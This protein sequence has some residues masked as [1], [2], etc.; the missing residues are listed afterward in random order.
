MKTPPIEYDVVIVGSGPTG[1]AYAR[2]LHEEAPRLR[3]L[4]VEAGPSLS[5]QPGLH[6]KNLQDPQERAA[7]QLASQGPVTSLSPES[8]V[9]GPGRP[10]TFL[11]RP[12][13]FAPL[14]GMPAAA[15]SSNVGGMGAHWTCACPRPGASERIFFLDDGTLDAALT[16]AER[17]L[18]VTAGAFIDAPFSAEVRRLL[19]HAF[20]RTGAT[21]IQPM[22][23]AVQKYPDGT[24]T[25]SGTDV[26]LGP[27]AEP[28]TRSDSFELL[29]QT[30]CQRVTLDAGRVTGVELKDL[31]TG[32]VTQVR[33]PAVVV[34]ADALRTPQLLFAS[35]VRPRAL[36]RYLNDQPQVISAVRLP[37]D[38][39]AEGAHAAGTGAALHSGV[40]W[41][42]YTDDEP[43]HGQVMQL[44][45]SPVPLADDDPVVP[46][47]VV[48]LGWFCATETVEENRVEF[49]DTS[50]DHYGMPRM[51]INYNL[52]W[53]DLRVIDEAKD[54]VTRAGKA[55]GTF[56]DDRPPFLLPA[57]SSLHYQ[58][59]VR[60]GQHDDG[61]SVCGPDSQV[62]GT[63]GLYVAG[64]GVIPTSTAC[65][66][67]LTSV[68]LA[69][70]GARSLARSLARSSQ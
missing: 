51:S 17:L 19:E 54:A 18:S 7:A 47:S 6:V 15:M 20:D 46:G 29:D 23:L 11:L 45:A 41:V 60:M 21:A 35:G 37:A 22:P 16:E 64:N 58:G 66:P 38:V 57:G 34:A 27:L 13:E 28:A 32:A 69:V 30:L 1:S 9:P 65:N 40:S 61:R 42:P 10:G 2:I 25:W 12:D 49:D 33:A 14:A 43:F 55:L 39:V 50:L 26:V 68:A 56:L 8:P 63:E 70:L 36:G 48:G 59:S 5:E 31:T 24:I 53:N 67:T 4:M 44:D 62:W 3:V 52:T